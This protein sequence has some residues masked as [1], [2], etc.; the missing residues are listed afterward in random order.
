MSSKIG[1]VDISAVQSAASMIDSLN[2]ELESIL[3]ATKTKVDG[4]LSSWQGTAASATVEA[5]NS[6]A[7][8]YFS[9]YKEML[10]DY[11]TFLRNNVATGYTEI[12]NL[13][14]RLASKM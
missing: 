7:A 12:E 11:V 10:A 3:M 1:S 6:F 4:L 2:N 14:K 13:N 8:K 9:N 5:Y